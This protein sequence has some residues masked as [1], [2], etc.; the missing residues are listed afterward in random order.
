M[1]TVNTCTK[2]RLLASGIVSLAELEELNTPPQEEASMMQDLT[3]SLVQEGRMTAFQQRRLLS[4]EE[5][6]LLIGQYVL[7]DRIGEG[8]MGAVFRS[9]HQRMQRVVALKLLHPKTQSAADSIDR[10]L[11]E[12]RAAGRLNHPNIIA[13]YD[14]GECDSGHFLVMEFVDGS[15]FKEILTQSGRLN[16]VQAIEVIRQV[17]TGLQYAHDQGVIHRDIKPANLMRDTSGTVKIADLGL[18]RITSGMHWDD[19][20]SQLTQAGMVSGTVDYMSPEQ[21]RDT[22]TVDNRTDIY[23]LGAT[24]YHLLTGQPMFVS[25]ALMDRL[26]SH[27]TDARPPLCN[28]IPD[29]PPELD[30]FYQKMTAVELDQ[31]FQSMHE[32]L[33]A[34]KTISGQQSP[35]SS[36]CAEWD[37]SAS[38]AIV[39]E[40]SR[41]QAR[42]VE[43]LLNEV[44]V[45]DVRICLNGRE[46]LA[47]LKT[48]P[49]D[50]LLSS[51]NLSDVSQSEFVNH[52]RNNMKWLSTAIVFMTSDSLPDA[53]ATRL[54]NR[55][56]VH[57]VNKPFSR[58]QLHDKLQSIAQSVPAKSK[59]AGFDDLNVLVV[60]DSLV[61]RRRV[62]DVLTELGFSRFQIAKDGTEAVDQLASQSFQLVV[63]DYNMPNMNGNELVAHIRSA[64][65]Q[66]DVPV[67]MVTTEHDPQKLMEVYQLGVSAVCNKSFDPAL[68]RNIV[69]QLFA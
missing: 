53:T 32:V 40:N 63:T 3:D 17:A 61:W 56:S 16:F 36:Q 47:L 30:S 60:D 57:V 54:L 44:G 1:N 50:F 22:S 18:A 4:T 55:N 19:P 13:A 43:K 59:M 65:N 34:L 29:C 26:I 9:L 52:I 35:N 31:R 58:Q 33:E 28:M 11:Q 21:A 37:P 2:Q 67:I 69:I 68:V 15:D 42:V 12:V 23:S 62:Q 48:L 6:P 27:R 24:L 10:F 66:R 49:A 64:R 41:L 38:V 8:G 45:E 51:Y 7:M 39:V 5:G 14:A 20:D 46:A 25:G